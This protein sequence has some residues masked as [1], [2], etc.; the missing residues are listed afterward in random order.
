MP[1][2]PLSN[3]SFGINLMGAISQEFTETLLS[4]IDAIILIAWLIH[5]E[6]RHKI[7]KFY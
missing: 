1:F 6:I 3:L 2:Y 7:S 4:G 5:E